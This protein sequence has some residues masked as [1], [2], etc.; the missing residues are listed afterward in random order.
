MST[1]CCS[2]TRTTSNG[3]GLTVLQ[4]VRQSSP[5]IYDFF[6]HRFGIY[7]K[8]IVEGGG[9]QKMGIFYPEPKLLHQRTTEYMNCFTQILKLE[10]PHDYNVTSSLSV[11]SPHLDFAPPVYISPLK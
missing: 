10:D 11:V 2:S 1:S 8:I 5:L 4:G 9:Y 3:L 7:S 6:F